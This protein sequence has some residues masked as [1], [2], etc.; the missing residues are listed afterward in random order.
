MKKLITLVASLLAVALLT[1]PVFAAENQSLAVDIT[2]I[3]I[4]NE[5]NNDLLNAATESSPVNGTRITTW[6]NT[7]HATQ[8]WD[9]SESVPGK[10]QH[11]W[12]KNSANRSYAV[13]CY[14][15][16]GQQVT[17]QSFTRNMTTQPVKFI[18]EGG[19]SFNIYGLASLYLA[20]P[21]PCSAARSNQSAAFVSSKN[22]DVSSACSFPSAYSAK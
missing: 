13:T 17:L 14:G 12:L 10:P 19:S 21:F 6:D 15:T 1:V 20:N 2:K 16:D 9:Y 22:G 4:S 18:N 3:S 7:G 8:R 5:A 11:Y